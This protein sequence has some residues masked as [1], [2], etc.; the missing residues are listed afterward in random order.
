MDFTNGQQQRDKPTKDYNY[1]KYKKFKLTMNF[2]F[3]I[4]EFW[5]NIQLLFFSF[6][7]RFIIA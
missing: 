4:H 3:D 1:K 2:P 5:I 7:C 6:M